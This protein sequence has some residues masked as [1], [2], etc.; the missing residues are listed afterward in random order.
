MRK[1]VSPLLLAVVAMFAMLLSFG[2]T[3]FA[4]DA[5][6]PDDGSSLLDLMKPAY[7]AFSGGHYAMGAALA[8]VLIVAVI[9]KYAGTAS[10][11]GKFVHSDAGGS[12]LALVTATAAAMGTALAAPGATITCSLLKTAGLVGVGAAGGYAMLKNLIVEPLLKPLAAKAPAWSQPIF[13]LV[14]WIFDH[15]STAVTDAEK[16]GADAV[17]ANPAPG[18]EGTAG[19]PTEL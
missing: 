2:A 18:V 10:K 5:A 7:E 8:V 15:G 1:I 19:K 16:A 11:F 6:T 12:L 13:A 4:A 3:S 14:F 17:K 9:K